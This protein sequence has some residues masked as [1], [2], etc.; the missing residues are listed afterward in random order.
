MQL[1][2]NTMLSLFDTSVG[3]IAN[4]SCEVWGFHK[5]PDIERIQLQFCK[6]LLVMKQSTPNDM[7]YYELG[8]H[9][10]ICIRKFRILKYWLKIVQ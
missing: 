10:L 5:A 4:Y 1:N 2:Y 9:P 7:I 8:R 3:S 6:Y